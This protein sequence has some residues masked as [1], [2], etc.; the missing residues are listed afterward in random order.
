MKALESRAA[1]T[2]IVFMAA[3]ILVAGLRVDASVFV[4]A[5][6]FVCGV[7]SSVPLTIIV[8]ALVLRYRERE[9]RERRRRRAERT[10]QSPVVIVQPP[11][12]AHLRQ[13]ASWSSQDEL[14]LAPARREFTMIGEGEET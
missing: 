11:G 3:M 4:F 1:L 12:V 2:G 6:G 7:A 8:T 5:F 9:S 14:T 13:P 10:P